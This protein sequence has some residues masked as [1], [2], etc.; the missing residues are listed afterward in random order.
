MINKKSYYKTIELNKRLEKISELTKIVNEGNLVIINK[1]KTI[2]KDGELNRIL[3]E[4]KSC[5]Y[6]HLYSEQYKIKQKI[7]EL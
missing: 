1:N 3:N 2:E 4:Y 5:L 6:N 7:N